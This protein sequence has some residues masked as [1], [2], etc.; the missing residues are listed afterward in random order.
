MIEYALIKSG[1]T[2]VLPEHLPEAPSVTT[3]KPERQVPP[4][5]GPPGR[6]VEEDTILLYVQEHGSIGN[7]ECQELL[8]VSRRQATYLLERLCQAGKLERQGTR[9]WTRYVDAIT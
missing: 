2:T 8:G 7:S 9:R 3:S 5:I 6:R 4:A 1:G